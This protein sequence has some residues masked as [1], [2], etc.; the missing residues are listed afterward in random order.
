MSN[1]INL[2]VSNKLFSLPAIARI[3]KNPR[4]WA[5]A[6]IALVVFAAYKAVQYHLKAVANYRQQI[7]YSNNVSSARQQT[8]GLLQ[9]E[10]SSLQHQVQNLTIERNQAQQHLRLAR[11]ANAKL[12]TKL[13]KTATELENLQVSFSSLR[14]ARR[15]DNVLVKTVALECSNSNWSVE[16]L[17]KTLGVPAFLLSKPSNAGQP[18]MLTVPNTVLPEQVRIY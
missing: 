18:C 15:G 16:T 9:G 11:S 10:I 12:I 8:I 4:T 5:L 1:I 6:G 3:A 2:T 13:R 17:A 7:A 14:S